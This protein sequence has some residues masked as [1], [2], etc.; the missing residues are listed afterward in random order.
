[1]RGCISLLLALGWPAVALAETL[2]SV[3]VRTWRPSSDPHAGLVLEPTVT[4]GPWAWNAGV[5]AHYSQSPV[6]LRDGLTGALV[7]RPLEH[8]LGADLVAGIGLGDRAAIGLDV[9]FFVWQDGS[10]SLPAA[11]VSRGAVASSGLGDAT[12]YGKATI[13]SNDRQGLRAGA[14][15]AALG[16]LTLPVGDRASLMGDGSVSTSLL[17][18]G[19]YALGVGAARAS[20]G[21]K[22]R[23]D[24]HT[25]PADGGPTF[26]DEIPWSIGL[27]LRPKAIATALDADDRQEWEIALHG[28]LPAGPVAPFGLGG[29]GAPSLS[30]VLLAVGDRIALG[31]TRD[32]YVVWGGDFGLDSAAGVPAFRAVLSV[33]WAPRTH[34]RDADG[35]PDDVDECPDLPE[36]KDGIQDSDGCPEDDADG[37]GIPDSTDACPLVQGAA[38]EDPQKNGC[39]PGTAVPVPK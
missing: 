13:I 24:W 33:G 27:V 6:V 25:W 10:A 20:L 31:H 22:L 2:P 38:N 23:T 18:L 32:A 21:Y 1:M 16:T 26:G 12:V 5:W 19:E 35:V 29:T 11:V 37:D 28:A 9:A 3:D 14:G 39:P 8:A 34:D 7:S 17:L 15:L 36:D 30:P 4:P